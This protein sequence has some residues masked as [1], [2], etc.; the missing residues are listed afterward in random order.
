MSRHIDIAEIK[1]ERLFQ[2]RTLR[3]MEAVRGKNMEKLSRAIEEFRDA[4]VP[5]GE[6]LLQASERRLAF[7]QVSEG[8]SE[9]AP[10][11]LV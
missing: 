4:Q 9:N 8:K 1:Q 7:L 11:M 6:E 3:L 2:K 5:D 10:N